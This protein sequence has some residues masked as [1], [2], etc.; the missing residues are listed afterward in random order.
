MGLRYVRMRVTTHVY[1]HARYW[2]IGHKY[3]GHVYVH[4]SL[5]C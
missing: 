3:T 2:L 4:V 5:T 1:L